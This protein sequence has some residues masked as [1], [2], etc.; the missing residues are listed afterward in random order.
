MTDREL[1]ELAAKAHG[2]I[3]DQTTDDDGDQIGLHRN[4]QGIYYVVHKF[5]WHNWAPLTDDGDALR[6]AVE[7]GLVLNLSPRKDCR[8]QTVVTYNGLCK[9]EEPCSD[10]RSIAARRAIVQA[11]AE[12][13]KAMP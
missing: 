12:I 3:D 13:G 6:L 7:L 4:G 10:G 1:L 11:A 2:F 8:G 5:G 9:I